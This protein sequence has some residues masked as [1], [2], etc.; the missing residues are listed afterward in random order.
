MK[1][2]T[3]F[4]HTYDGRRMYFEEIVSG[5]EPLTLVLL[6]GLTQ[7]TASWDLLL[8]E[9]NW[10]GKIILCDLIFQGKS[11]KHG[12]SKNFD[13]HAS[14]VLALLA[15]LGVKQAIVAGISYGSLLAQHFAVNHPKSLSRL[16][17]L[18][19]FA[20]KTP[21]YRAIE[22]SWRHSLQTGGYELMLDVML[23]FVLGENYFRS[24]LIPIDLMKSMRI[25]LKPQK[26]ALL[27]LM[28]ATENRKDYLKELLSIECPTL[29]IQGENDLLF[30]PSFAIAVNNHIK[31]SQLV[32]LPG[33]GHTLNLEACKEIAGSIMNFCK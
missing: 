5:S 11:D 30:P 16:I 18:S 25:D 10:N 14:D 6:N 29:I 22:Q 12:P 15:Y 2:R 19:T 31:N 26:D 33:K 13:Q 20:H 8:K 1:K 24:P 7:T 28:E 17:L 9:L 23:P 3:E 4:F 21:M 27:K 32:I